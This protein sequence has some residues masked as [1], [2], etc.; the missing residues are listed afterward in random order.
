MSDGILFQHCFLLHLNHFWSFHISDI[1]V[2]FWAPGE[3]K[4]MSH[5]SMLL[6]QSFVL[7]SSNRPHHT[8]LMKQINTVFEYF[9]PKDAF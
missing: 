1:F 7:S 8:V 3:E 5:T 2:F 6:K 4:V 9:T